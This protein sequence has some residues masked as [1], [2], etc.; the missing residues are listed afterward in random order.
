MKKT[1]H[2]GTSTWKCTGKL[3]EQCGFKIPRKF[4][5]MKRQIA[6]K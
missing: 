1:K 6:E 2:I 3:V 4:S 5:L